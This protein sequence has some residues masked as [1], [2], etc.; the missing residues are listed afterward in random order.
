MIRKECKKKS[1]K[2]RHKT[3]AALSKEMI[4]KLS[5][6]LVTGLGGISHVGLSR[7]EA[8]VIGGHGNS[9]GRC[10]STFGILGHA[11]AGVVEGLNR[12]VGFID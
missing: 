2:K 9:N 1:H 6:M 10:C 3:A 8:W 4:L 11:D 5:S 12:L 7:A